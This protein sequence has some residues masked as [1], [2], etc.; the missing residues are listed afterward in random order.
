MKGVV[1]AIVQ[2]YP[3][4]SPCRLCWSLSCGFEAHTQTVQR[5]PEYHKSQRRCQGM[6][7]VGE[8]DARG[9]DNCLIGLHAQGTAF[10]ALTRPLAKKNLA[11]FVHENPAYILTICPTGNAMLKKT[12]PRLFPESEIWMEKICDFTEFVVKKGLL[13]DGRPAHKIKNV[14]YHYPCHYV[15][16]LG[17][18]EE[19][20]KLLRSIGYNPVVEEEPFA[21]CGFSGIF[22]FKNPDLAAHL[23][24]KKEDKI[25]RQEITT[26]AT[27]CPGC[28]FQFKA[29]LG[30][31][32]DSYE[33][34][35]TA[36]LFARY[37][38]ADKSNTLHP[39]HK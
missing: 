27:D 25:K 14:F 33:V 8:T 11:S 28:L 23:W 35:H 10:P 1:C 31:K 3:S 6:S 32:T 21:C 26:I 30:K 24:Q 19:P 37:M 39:A 38:T 20:L 4:L 7:L 5:L 18:R 17:L 36:E 2:E 12:Y 16:E 15:N 22:S 29:C 9:P 13:P 34:F